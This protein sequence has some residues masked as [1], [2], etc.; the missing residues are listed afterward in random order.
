MV[1]LKFEAVVGDSAARGA[2]LFEGFQQDGKVGGRGIEA[3]DDGDEFAATFFPPD[4][5]GLICGPA[6]IAVGIARAG[7]R[8]EGLFA[9]L[10]GDGAVEFSTGEQS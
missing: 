5:G 3:G 9:D 2:L 6:D 4:T 7:T 10:A 8:L 1:A